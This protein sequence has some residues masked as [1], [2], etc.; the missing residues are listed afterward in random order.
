VVTYQDRSIIGTAAIAALG[1]SRRREIFE[2][3]T[4]GPSSVAQIALRLPVT[5]PAVSQHLRV[6][7]DAGLV[8]SRTEGTRHMYQLDPLGIAAIRDYF[9]K[10][11][12]RALT[13]FKNFAEQSYVPPDQEQENQT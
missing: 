7:K 12:Q 8:T 10:L 13:D 4:A 3:L 6:L 2:I 1:D 5:R 11:W 9:D